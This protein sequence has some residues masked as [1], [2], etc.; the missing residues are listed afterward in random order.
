MQADLPLKILQVSKSLI[1]ARAAMSL[2]RWCLGRQ[3]YWYGLGL[4]VMPVVGGVRKPVRLYYGHKFICGKDHGRRLGVVRWDLDPDEMTA[5]YR[6]GV[7]FTMEPAVLSLLDAA[8]NVVLAPMRGDVAA[9]IDALPIPRDLAEVMRSA[10]TCCCGACECT[11]FL[12]AVVPCAEIVPTH[13]R[14]WPDAWQAWM[15]PSCF[16]RGVERGEWDAS[17]S[18]YKVPS[19]PS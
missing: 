15:R 14:P 7:V 6:A 11:R 12:G 13:C 5:R 3:V 1:G 16:R 2:A 10:H 9:Q 17:E 18:W 19:T 8:A 4:H